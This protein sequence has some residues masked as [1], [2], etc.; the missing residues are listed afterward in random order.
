MEVLL[1]IAVVLGIAYLA[2]RKPPVPEPEP[3]EPPEPVPPEPGL[4]GVIYGWIVDSVSKKP[5]SNVL[6]EVLE[7]GNSAK[8]DGGGLFVVKDIP[9]NYLAFY[10]VRF[11][12]R[13]YETLEHITTFVQLN[14]EL[15]CLTPPSPPPLYT[16][17]ITGVFFSYQNYGSSQRFKSSTMLPGKSCHYIGVVIK[18]TTPDTVL[19]CNV[20]AVIKTPK[21]VIKK[22]ASI[23]VDYKDIYG[24]GTYIGD[25]LRTWDRGIYQ[26]SIKL[27]TGK[28]LLDIQNYEYDLS[29]VLGTLGGHV[30]D[31]SGKGISGLETELYDSSGA[32]VQRT[33]TQT[34][35]PGWFYFVPIVFPE[36]YTIKIYYNSKVK[37]VEFYADSQD[38]Y[39]GIITI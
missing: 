11:S 36:Q 34:S 5:V 18:N 9:K 15:T 37:E 14:I 33:K 12:H 7:T 2:R 27:G 26:I 4:K 8:S 35:R 32:L 30:K 23:N 20:E 31:T 25:R 29:Q 39:A 10:T 17:E 6:V 13:N 38:S 24:K 19:L 22:N 3:P 21:E 1:I 16:G 28:T